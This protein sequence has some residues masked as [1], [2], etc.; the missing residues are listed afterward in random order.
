MD[1]KKALD[2]V[3]HRILLSKLSVF[4]NS[5]YSLLFFCSYLKNRVQRVFIRG[6]YSSEGTVKY[7][8]TQRSVLGPVLFCI[9]IND[10]PL[11]I[12]T[13]SAECHMLTGDTILH[14]TG[15][16][17]RKIKFKKATALS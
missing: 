9:Y 5:S 16:A 15:T 3:D 14:T 2:F 10:L 11:H 1:L 8:V 6:S 4:L 13:H 7:G 12:P 17:L